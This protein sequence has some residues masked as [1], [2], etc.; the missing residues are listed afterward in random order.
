[1]YSAALPCRRIMRNICGWPPSPSETRSLIRC[2]VTLT[3]SAR[4]ISASSPAYKAVIGSILWFPCPHS[5][6][7]TRT[8]RLRLRFVFVVTSHPGHAPGQ[9]VFIAALRRHVEKIIGA[10]QDV[11]AAGI[12]GIGV[13]HRAAVL[14]EGAQSRQLRTVHLHSGVVVG[15]GLGIDVVLTERHAEVAVE[16]GAVGRHPL[17]LPAHALLVGVDLG[18]RRA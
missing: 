7:A 16:I 5:A 11:E 15:H 4:K 6:A 9:S 2:M 1:M 17:E 8:R 10:E 13:K 14:D 18:D 12:G 3:A